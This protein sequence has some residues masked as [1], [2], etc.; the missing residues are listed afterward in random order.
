MLAKE[1]ILAS[2]S[3]IRRKILD[4]NG[5]SY[6]AKNHNFD[7]KILKTDKALSPDNLSLKL[8]RGKAMSL[9]DEFFNHVILGC[10]QV[11][12]LKDRIFSE[13]NNVP[14]NEDVW[15]LFLGGNAQKVLKLNI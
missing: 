8:A 5:V 3:D 4:D 10:D 15:P 12:L 9:R 2:S 1:L 14:F 7:E 6:I 11:C 13:M